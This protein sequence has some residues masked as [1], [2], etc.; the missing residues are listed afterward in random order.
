MAVTAKRN[1]MR[2]LA[3]TLGEEVS[4][5]RNKETEELLNY[6]FNQYEIKVIKKQGDI[7]DKIKI[8]KGNISEINAILNE[9]ITIL[10]AKSEEDKKYNE[11]IILDDI[12]LPIKRNDKVGIIELYDNGNKIGTY[13]LVSDKDVK[14]RNFL[15]IYINNLFDI[16]FGNL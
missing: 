6:G 12:K 3:I 7:I 5:V 2:L 15:N 9:N 8:S 14:K 1:D 4:K 16:L 13:Q 10:K 11:E